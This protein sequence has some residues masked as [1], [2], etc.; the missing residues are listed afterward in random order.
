VG[1]QSGRQR[2]KLADNDAQRCTAHRKNGERCRKFAIAGSKVCRTHGGAAKQVQQAAR[3]RLA[4]AADRMA[5]ELLKMAVDENV[6][7]SVKLAAIKDALDRG[8]LGA[9]TE[10]EITAKPYETIL[11][12]DCTHLVIAPVTQQNP[13]ERNHTM[14]DLDNTDASTFSLYCEPLDALHPDDWPNDVRRPRQV[15]VGAGCTWDS[16]SDEDL[17]MLSVTQ[18]DKQAAVLLN[19]DDLRAVIGRLAGHLPTTEEN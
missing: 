18:D 10:V 7:D 2:R 9:K 11:D 6:S 15:F 1:P 13:T 4:N 5:R 12:V 8:G 17:T 19:L 16:H 14:I 3:A